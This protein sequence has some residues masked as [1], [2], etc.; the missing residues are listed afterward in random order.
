MKIQEKD[1]FENSLIKHR[2]KIVGRVRYSTQDKTVF[3]STKNFREYLLTKDFVLY[4]LLTLEKENTDP[5][6]WK[7]LEK[8]KLNRSFKKK[9]YV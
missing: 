7:V 1:L 9:W 2:N 6:S 3:Y 5:Q 4:D 8:R